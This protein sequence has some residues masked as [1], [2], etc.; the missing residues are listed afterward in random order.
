[1][2]KNYKIREMA[3]LLNVSVETLRRW[4][5]EDILKSYRTPTN[6]R[7]YTHSQYLDYMG[8]SLK[9]DNKGKT[10]LYARV[11][12]R[13]QKD[14]LKNQISFLRDFANSRGWIIDEIVEDIGSGL[15]YKRKQWNKLL[16][17]IL[18]GKIR[19]VI[20]AHKDRFVR[21]GFEWFESFLHDHG[22]ELV[23]VNNEELSPEEELVQDLIAIIH[24]FS[25]RI[26]GLRK[27]KT[28]IREELH[29]KSI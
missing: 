15:N 27:Y 18:E 29:A 21:F 5:N 3:E 20:V 2:D 4:D 16:T 28:K 17:S 14:D 6:R 8:I 11:S 12:N 25:C 22:V 7:Y 13:S 26:Y 24:V 1:M 19:R 23:V 9:E 10:V